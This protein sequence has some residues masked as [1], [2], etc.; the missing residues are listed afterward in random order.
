VLQGRILK[1]IFSFQGI[2]SLVTNR[3]ATGRRAF[4]HLYAMRLKHAPTGKIYWLHQDTTMYQ[5]LT[6]PN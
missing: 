1:Q 6:N 5:V 4:E 3:L 2:I